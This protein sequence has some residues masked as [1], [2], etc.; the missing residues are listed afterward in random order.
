MRIIFLPAIVIPNASIPWMNGCCSNL[1]F[2]ILY[3]Y[4]SIS[5]NFLTLCPFSPYASFGHEIRYA[6][7]EPVVCGK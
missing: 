1:F 2:Y 4:L 3:T 7:S 5:T 6:Y